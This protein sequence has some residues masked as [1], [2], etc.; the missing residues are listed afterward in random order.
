MARLP[1]RGIEQKKAGYVARMSDPP[2]HLFEGFGVELEYMIVDAETLDVRPISDEL[3]Q[4]VAGEIVSTTS[5][6]GDI[7]W[8]NEL[9]LHVIEL[10]TTG[11]LPIA[12]AAGRRRFRSTSANQRACSRPLGARLMPTA[13]HPWMD[14]HREMRLWPH[15]YSAVYEAFNRIFDCRG[16]GWANLQ[17]VH[18]NLPFRGRRGVRPAA[19][20]HPAAAADPARAGRQLAGDRGQATG[21]IDNRLE[22]FDQLAAIPDRRPGDP[23]AGLTA[24]STRT[25]SSTH[26]RRRGAARSRGHAARRVAQRPR[27]DRR[28]DRGAIEIRVLDV[29]ECPAAH[30]TVRA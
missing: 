11:P 25:A 9:A 29:Q 4:A 10:K 3:L 27:R 12:G 7:S 6:D 21:I 16:H 13:M 22:M 30:C 26:L 15:E 23:R 20:G 5:I 1:R 18:L 14:P 19:R 24:S 8:S 17:S 28:F 2:L